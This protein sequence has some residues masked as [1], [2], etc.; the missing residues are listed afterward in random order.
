MHTFIR[1]D[2]CTVHDTC[3][4][5]YLYNAQVHSRM[6]ACT[7][8]C[9]HAHIYT[10]MRRT[11]MYDMHRITTRQATRQLLHYP[12]NATATATA[13]ATAAA[14]ATAAETCAKRACVGSLQHPPYLG[15]LA[16]VQEFLGARASSLIANAAESSDILHGRWSP[17]YQW[18]LLPRAFA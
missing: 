14:A 12:A 8:A 5:V 9:I 1:H 4:S 7:Q 16:A 17:K 3:A 10:Y 18:D 2:T 11:Y 15:E 13:T 6:H